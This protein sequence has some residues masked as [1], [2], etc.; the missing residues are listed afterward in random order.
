LHWI[1]FNGAL[2]SYGEIAPLYEDSIQS[3]YVGHWFLLTDPDGRE[4]V[5][6]EAQSAAALAVI[7]DAWLQPGSA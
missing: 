4:A 2:V 1:D 7:D 5:M 6:F 3:T